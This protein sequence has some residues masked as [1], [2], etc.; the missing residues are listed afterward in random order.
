MMDEDDGVILSDDC[1][2]VDEAA[3]SIRYQTRLNCKLKVK[4][5]ILHFSVRIFSCKSIPDAFLDKLIAK[6]HFSRFGRVR[7]FILRPS[8]RSC[9]IEYE[10]ANEAEN[11]FL[12][13]A[14]YN[15]EQFDISYAENPMPKPK[16]F[17]DAIDP[18]VQDELNAMTAKTT[19]KSTPRFGGKCSIQ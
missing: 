10:N 15:G 11:A 2:I 12:D 5:L 7:N 3:R 19:N 4:I 9:T 17:A 16:L 6:K 14:L 1:R 13:G 8:K 18:D